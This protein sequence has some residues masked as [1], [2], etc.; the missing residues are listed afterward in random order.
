MREHNVI[1]IDLGA[2][3]G[4][5]M[6]IRQQGSKL[7]LNEIHRFSNE[8]IRINE[9][10]YTDLFH[11][12]QEIL[13][14]LKKAVLVLGQIDG[15]GIDA[16]GHDFAILDCKGE[17]MRM[18]YQYR[19]SQNQGMLKEAERL[20]GK[21]YLFQQTGMK[22]FWCNTVY[23]IMGIRQRNEDI[24]KDAAYILLIPDAL[25]YLLTNTKTGEFT[26][27]TLTQMYDI[28]RKEWVQAIID[29][30]GL[31]TEMLPKILPHGEVKG[32]LTEEILSIIGLSTNRKIPL[33]NVAEH[34]TAAAA[35]AA[36][37]DLEQY[38]FISSGTWS[39]IGTVLQKPVISREVY[40]SG[41]ANEGAAYGKTKL[42][43][44]VMGMWFIQEL[45]KIWKR[46]GMNTDYGHLI[47][48]AGASAA[49]S[50]FINV[51]DAI[52]NSPID[53]EAAMNQFFD[54]TGQKAAVS[55]GEFYRAVME[56]LAYTYRY[57]IDQLRKL[58]GF[59]G[60]TVYFLGG[61]ARDTMFC[62]FIA[63]ATN[64]RVCAGPVEATSIGNAL[65]QLR[66]MSDISESEMGKLRRNVDIVYYQP[67]SPELWDNNYKKFC[68]I[69]EKT[70]Q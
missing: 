70:K 6:H 4:R 29:R 66:T 25:A 13:Q 5:L 22:D 49:F 61:A 12:Y 30:L 57:A 17:I 52:F 47:R 32:Y 38:I 8:G 58:T 64:C 37:A 1:A 16:W 15:V 40:E 33:F 9:R 14:G 51:E 68:A 11:I 19:D 55:Q 44:T 28:N 54:K 42:V 60:D 27:A 39:I 63:D 24:L 18:P 65:M 56:S 31:Q 26:S 10:I 43:K 7:E 59:A 41:F 48:E 50:R 53:M 20:F 2:S 62:R 46:K 36:P 45:R 35:Y 34:D 67:Q 3:S 21:E 23:Q 69:L